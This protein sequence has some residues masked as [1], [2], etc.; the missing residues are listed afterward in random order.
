MYDHVTKPCD[1]N[2]EKH[3]VRTGNRRAFA[4]FAVDYLFQ[5]RPADNSTATSCYV[6]I[7]LFTVDV[8]AVS[9]PQRHKIVIVVTS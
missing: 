6:V 5:Q 2:A 8:V 7:A 9:L 3:V 4:K 1:A